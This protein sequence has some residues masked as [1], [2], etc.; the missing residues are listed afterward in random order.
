MATCLV[1]R[2]MM[3]SAKSTNVIRPRPTGIS[4]S[5]DRE[6]QRHAEFA[7]ARLLVAQH[8]H[9]QALHGEAPHHAERVGLAEDEDV[10]AAQDD[11]EQLQAHDQVE[12]AV[13]SPEAPMRLAEPV[14]Q[15]AVLGDAVQHAV[16][17]HDRGVHRSGQHQH[18]DEHHEALKHQPQRVRA[19][20]NSWPGRRSGCRNTAARTASGMIMTAK[21]ETP[22]VKTRL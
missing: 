16:R 7:L 5:A 19:R 6:I 2:L 17:A 11:G 18:A 4:T 22:A 1:N 21:K 9:R 3:H 14:R 12:H 13:G 10:S 15:N 8:Q 20:Q